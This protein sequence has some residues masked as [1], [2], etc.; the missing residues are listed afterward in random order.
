[1]SPRG[2]ADLGSD[3]PPT[4]AVPGLDSREAVAALARRILTPMLAFGALA[5]LVCN[6]TFGEWLERRLDAVTAARVD[7]ALTR[8]RAEAPAPATLLGTSA[9]MEWVLLDAHRTAVLAG[10]SATLRN[11]APASLTDAGDDGRYRVL[12][13][14]LDDTPASSHYWLRLDLAAERRSHLVLELSLILAAAGFVVGMLLL[15]RRQLVRHLLPPLAAL[16]VTL[17]G[18]LDEAA[19]GR[20]ADQLL[21]PLL[22]DAAK[23]TAFIIES[24]RRSEDQRLALAHAAQRLH[25]LFDWAPIALLC[26]DDSGRITRLNASA[27][28]LLGL[29]D[30]VRELPV[31]DAF[32]PAWPR[33]A[34]AGV[35]VTLDAEVLRGGE[36]V[37]VIVHS[38]LALDGDLPEY[39]L[40]LEDLS[41]RKRA[42]T[43]LRASEERYRRMFETCNE[44]IW[45]LDAE[46][47][48]VNANA[49]L[50]EF[51]CGTAGQLAARPAPAF[52]ADDPAEF[53]AD[54]RAT[55]AGAA[56]A[57]RE[58]AFH[59]CDESIG[60]AM[61][62][63]T[64]LPQGDPGAG[65]LVLMLSDITSLKNA[66]HAL[67][68]NQQRLTTAAA[69]GDI[70]FWE[71][72]CQSG[73]IELD[74]RFMDLVTAGNMS[75]VIHLDAFLDRCHPEDTPTLVQRLH[76][77]V[78]GLTPDYA[79]EF[80]MMTVERGYR[81]YRARGQIVAR[82]EH[83]GGLRMVGIHQ[84]MT[85]EKLATEAL[86]MARDAA[87]QAAVVKSRFLAD[88]SHELRTPL[89]GVLGMLSLLEREMLSDEQ[90]EFVEVA[91]KS[92]RSLFELIN[93]VL[94]FSK[95]EAR[96]I[97][98]E[99]IE[100]DLHT[101]AEDVVD[102]LAEHAYQR[103]LD[104]VMCRDPGLPRRIQTDPA[105]LRQVLLNLL[106]NAVKFTDRG[107]VMLTLREAADG[108]GC[109]FEVSDT[110]IGIP[111]AQHA[112]IFEP[113]KQ[114]DS[115]TTRRFG[116]TGLGLSIT[117]QLVI[118]MGGELT[119]DSAPGKG[120]RFSFELPLT[121]QPSAGEPGPRVLAERRILLQEPNS[122]VAAAG[123]GL[124]R[125][126]G[127]TVV[128]VRDLRDVRPAL[129]SAER[130]FDLVIFATADDLLV[131][132]RELAQIRAHAGLEHLKLM[133]TAPFGRRIEGADL[134]ALGVHGLITKPMRESHVLRAIADL[135]APGAA[136]VDSAVGGATQCVGPPALSELKVMVVDD[137]ITNL[138]VAA[139]MLGKLGIKATLVDS[140]RAALDALSGAEFQ[141]IFMDCQ[142]PGMDGF[143]TTALIRARYLAG[144]GPR[145]IAMTANA[146]I[147][148]RDRCLANGMDDYLAKPVLLSD[149]ERVMYRWIGAAAP[150]LRLPVAASVPSASAPIDHAKLEELAGMLG[151]AEFDVLCERFR[152]DGRL[153]IERMTRNLEAGD[154]AAAR[155]AAHA[156]KGA[157]ANLGAT[158]LSSLCRQCETAGTLDMQA[159]LP[160]IMAAFEQ[161]CASLGERAALAA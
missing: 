108:G 26:C 36:H 7:A 155:Q 32:L 27:A 56:M 154:R 83:G 73:A 99:Q 33:P 79:M 19:G 49:R 43:A 125:A 3:A 126:H 146:A 34:S 8:L 117:R 140:G 94:D 17:K 148:D 123:A 66:E 22:A 48:T 65:A 131:I 23:L 53:G 121:L 37:P 142:M 91:M 39:V 119:L 55:L 137:V 118:L 128:C 47:C 57:P 109:R 145:I 104:I 82:D 4:A 13:G 20:D 143:E 157:A 71:Y 40:M 9:G 141:I 152:R 44:G 14:A 151:A 135:L 78:A 31:L 77:H 122:A 158:L 86:A 153:Q 35:L 61:V 74:Q 127:A 87:V 28:M 110:G 85:A 156:L 90:R 58:V 50:C 98:I 11:T 60:W 147:T 134:R 59:R 144:E 54:L 95:I 29:R 80:R 120:S 5:I 92:G 67:R 111:E 112:R 46:L 100:C 42:E 102:M 24:R 6:L 96:G 45:V 124:L 150:A 114:A 93:N 12:T 133:A 75:P 130:A 136:P 15:C 88:M 16:E 159:A 149:L 129:E 1:M 51:L 52:A 72:D 64:A 63:A 38:Y 18:Q 76:D 113:F 97:V 105:R 81:W 62:S 25:R 21:A 138:K 116:G 84:D 10:S 89:N 70:A 103:G 2:L 161:Y 132:G 106:G 68:D 101:L 107:Q 30:T 160:G 69:N 115:T 41:V 139:G